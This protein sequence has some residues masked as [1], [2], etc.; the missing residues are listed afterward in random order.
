MFGGM[1]KTQSLMETPPKT[2]RGKH[3]RVSLP[4][5]PTNPCLWR[6]WTNPLSV[7]KKKKK[8]EGR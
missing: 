2:E 7:L 3:S 1:E 8:K 4:P 5:P 6:P